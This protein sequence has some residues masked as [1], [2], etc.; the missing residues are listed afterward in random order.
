MKLGL[1]RRHKLSPARLF[2]CSLVG[3]AGADFGDA[4]PG[5]AQESSAAQE[6]AAAPTAELLRPEEL[7]KLVAPV[8]LY[9]DDLL[10]VVLP[11]STNP[12]QIVQ[13]QR[14]LDKRK[15]DQKL[16][17]NSE[18]DPPIL[19]LINYPEV[20]SKMNADLDWTESLGNAVIDQQKDVM[21]MIQ[22]IRAETYAGGYLKSDEKQV[23]VQEKETIIIQSADPEYIYVPSYDP[24]VVYVDHGPY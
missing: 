23:V 18:W 15:T 2:L 19:A 7:R 16:E 1:L 11:A 24:Q 22:Q 9:P 12:L 17:P 20:V 21:D 6:A 14:F 10:A 8:A 4:A 5:W 13:A 3:W